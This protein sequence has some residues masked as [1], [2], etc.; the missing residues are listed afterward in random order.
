MSRLPAMATEVLETRQ[1][2]G[3][4]CS[5]HSQP[6]YVHLPAE[7][8]ALLEEAAGAERILQI[9]IHLHFLVKL[10]TKAA[11]TAFM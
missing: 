1:V 4:S 6:H 7:V 5:A 10:L 9:R 2:P 11:A 8:R 3:N